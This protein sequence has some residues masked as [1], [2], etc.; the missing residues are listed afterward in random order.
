MRIERGRAT[1][2]AVSVFSALAWTAG[3]IP[4][5][6]QALQKSLRVTVVDKAGNDVSGLGPSDFIVREDKATR[7]VLRVAPADDPMQIV[8]LVDDTPQ[9]NRYLVDVRSALTAFVTAITTDTPRLG[10]HQIAILTLASRP[11]VKSNYTSDTN[12]LVKAVNSI[13]PQPATRPTLLDGIA[14][15]ADGLTKRH[16]TRPVIIAVSPEDEDASFRV[17]DQVLEDIDKSGAT[18]YAIGLG[19]PSEQRGRSIVLDQGSKASGGT[20][21][22]ALASNGLGARMMRLASHLTHQYLVTYARPNSL[23]PP[24]HVTVSAAKPG[25]TA[26]GTLVKEQ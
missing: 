24:D 18:F 25:L 5:S 19:E 22:T 9:L 13:I 26:R 23:I 3:S 6:A 16:A 20:Y 21:E 4:L 17:Y 14:E 15:A 10:R 8:L 1:I 12:A 11:T 7:E 2:L